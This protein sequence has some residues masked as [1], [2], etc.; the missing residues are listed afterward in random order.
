MIVSTEADGI[1]HLGVGGYD[2]WWRQGER[3]VNDGD[4]WRLVIPGSVEP[5]L[6]G[7]TAYLE[8]WSEGRRGGLEDGERRGAED[9]REA[10]RKA[11]GVMSGESTHRR[12]CALEPD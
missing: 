3:S 6:A 2:W 12:L 9:A 10:I 11:L 8:G 1:L 4:G 7:V 5:T